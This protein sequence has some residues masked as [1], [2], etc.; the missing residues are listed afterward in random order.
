MIGRPEQKHET[1][2]G[3]RQYFDFRE[4]YDSMFRSARGTIFWPGINADIKKLA[5]CCSICQKTKH[6][7]QKAPLRQHSEG[8]APW[9][10]MG[11]V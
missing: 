6:M 7:N 5:D 4:T 3:I 8:S 1:P 9:Q 10:S 11:L 2:L